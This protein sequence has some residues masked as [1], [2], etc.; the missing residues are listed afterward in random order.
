MGWKLIKGALAGLVIALL[1]CS[2]APTVR[3][4]EDYRI[5]GTVHYISATGGT[6]TRA[7]VVVS[8]YNSET[9][10]SEE[11]STSSS[12]AFDLGLFE[13]GEGY[14]ITVN[15]GD[16]DPQT[17]TLSPSADAYTVQSDPNNNYG[18]V[19]D[20]ACDSEEG[21]R[22]FLKFSISSIPS[23]VQIQSAT[24]KLY[25]ETS[26]KTDYG[27]V[28]AYSV[29]DDSWAEGTV[30]WNNQPAL[31]SLLDTVT[32]TGSLEG[33]WSWD[34]TSHVQ[35][36]LSGDQTVSFGLNS[37]DEW[38]VWFW[39]KD[40][41][42]D[43]KLEVTYVSEGPGPVEHSFTLSEDVQFM[44]VADLGASEAYF[45][46]DFELTILGEDG[47]SFSG[48][49]QSLPTV[50]LSP[51]NWYSVDGG[52]P[53]GDHLTF[54][55]LPYGVYTLNIT[56][57]DYESYQTSISV[58]RQAVSR[59]VTLQSLGATSTTI[60]ISPGSFT[61]DSGQGTTLTATLTSD[62]TPLAGK[63]INWAKDAGNLSAASGT[64]DS[65]GQVSITYTAPTVSTQ[66]EV[67]VA[68]SFE[69]D[70]Q[71]QSSSGYSTGMVTAATDTDNDGMPDNWET[72]NGLDPNDSSD[73]S[74]DSD[75][76]NYTN[77]QEYQAGTDPNLASSYPGASEEEEGEEEPTGGVPSYLLLIAVAVIAMV[78][79][80]A[81][82]AWLRARRGGEEWE[83]EWE[84]E[85]TPPALGLRLKLHK[86]SLR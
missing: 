18:S 70:D 9:G 25:Y 77:L 78:G 72:Q 29:S 46:N 23:Y 68:A 62:G 59:T 53:Q 4:Q 73:A 63:T 39:S 28:K 83:S 35:S 55:W 33:W 14:T 38:N 34:V 22:S 3:G 51:A 74:I 42:N 2:C 45:A 30:T 43:P 15:Y 44:S 84:V 19:W 37:A 21:K 65:S 60:A 75:G 67:T 16:H 10:V 58:G 54:S 71:Y 64:T 81:A 6:F 86:L 26:E 66:T 36:E 79:A 47:Q 41:T 56:H 32:K 5:S 48:L 12:G 50:S 80:V 85:A 17:E 82:L 27:S 8:I 13:S 11:T 40:D 20:L 7:G 61:L 52:Y 31:G 24:L 57:P 69:G 76:D 49:G 1:V